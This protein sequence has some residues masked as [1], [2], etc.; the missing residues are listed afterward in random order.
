LRVD[1]RVSDYFLTL[2]HQELGA[3]AV[4]VHLEYQ[5]DEDQWWPL[6]PLGTPAPLEELCQQARRL[7]V[8]VD[9]R[10]VTLTFGEHTRTV[11]TDDEGVEPNTLLSVL[12]EL[13][14]PAKRLAGR[15]DALV[16]YD[17][18]NFGAV[19]IVVRTLQTRGFF[20]LELARQ[21]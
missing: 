5:D 7:V 9:T 11:S 2:L 6:V 10:V 3:R 13:D 8:A 16:T 12:G 20:D 14:G 1:D 15:S 18:A 17:G 19:A 4:A 21:P